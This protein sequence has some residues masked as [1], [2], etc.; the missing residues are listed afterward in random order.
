MP[1]LLVLILRF[2]FFFLEQMQILAVPYN[3]I[4]DP[5]DKPVCILVV[6]TNQQQLAK[7]ELFFSFFFFKKTGA[8]NYFQISNKYQLYKYNEYLIYMTLAPNSGYVKYDHELNKGRL[9]LW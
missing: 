1:A 6:E 3:T 7:F 5:R 8:A 2:L 4:S 9:S